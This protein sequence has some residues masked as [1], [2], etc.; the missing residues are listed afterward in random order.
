[1]KLEPESGNQISFF[2]LFIYRFSETV[3]ILYILLYTILIMKLYVLLTVNF[4]FGH[5]WRSIGAGTQTD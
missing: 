1:M 3:V 2:S 5:N 4:W